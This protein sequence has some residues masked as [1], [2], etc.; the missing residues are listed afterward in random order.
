MTSYILDAS[1][2]M[3]VYILINPVLL[4]QLEAIP[5]RFV[6]SHDKLAVSGQQRGGHTEQSDVAKAAR[7]ETAPFASS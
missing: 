6:P 2:I 1:S 7:T 3:P 4:V 5:G